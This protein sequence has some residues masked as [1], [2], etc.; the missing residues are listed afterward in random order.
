M[1]KKYIIVEFKLVFYGTFISLV[2][3]GTTQAEKILNPANSTQ[4]YISQ[5]FK[6]SGTF[7]KQMIQTETSGKSTHTAVL[8]QSVSL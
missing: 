1:Y 6:M 3:R 5:H 7:F 4:K 2:G 8:C